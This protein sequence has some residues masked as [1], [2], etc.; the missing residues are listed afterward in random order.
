MLREWTKLDLSATWGKL[1]DAAS[2]VNC[3]VDCV[4]GAAAAISTEGNY[5]GVCKL[6]NQLLQI[7]PPTV[8]GYSW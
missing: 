4:R 2:I 1:I 6:K 5:S 7:D 8:V 3:E